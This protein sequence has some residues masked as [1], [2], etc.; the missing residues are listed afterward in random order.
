MIFFLALSFTAY[1][2]YLFYCLVLY[3]ISLYILYIYC[4]CN[5]LSVPLLPCLSH[6]EITKEEF[7]CSTYDNKDL[8]SQIVLYEMISI[9]QAPSSWSMVAVRGTRNALFVVV[10]SSPS[11][12][13]RSSQIRASTTACPVTR[14][15]SPHTVPTAKRWDENC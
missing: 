15:D 2:L 13:S 14:D 7:H 11:A 1:C 9:S 3:W 12:P 6:E 8:E 5:L 4:L 10:V